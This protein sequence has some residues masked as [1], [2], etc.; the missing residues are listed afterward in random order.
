MI[1]ALAL[2]LIVVWIVGLRLRV[3]AIVKLARQLNKY[4]LNPLMLRLAGQPSWYAA[5]VHHVGRRSGRAYQTPVVAEPLDDGFAIPLPY[6]AD[7]D[8]VRNVV[9]AGRCTIQRRGV[10]IACD[11]PE[12]VSYAAIA[13]RLPQ[14]ARRA[15]RLLGLDKYLVVK[16]LAGEPATTGT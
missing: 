5:V 15:Q 13:D 2:L 9:A 11:Q 14:R 3:P 1:R 12:I 16:E 7:V 10:S 4:V 6:G 8:W